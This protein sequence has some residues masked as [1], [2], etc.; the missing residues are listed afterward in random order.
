MPVRHAGDVRVDYTTEHWL[1]LV[2]C[3]F[4]SVQ[5]RRGAA[6]GLAFLETFSLSGLELWNLPSLFVEGG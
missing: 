5:A 3:A 2:T 1:S 6:T 4:Y